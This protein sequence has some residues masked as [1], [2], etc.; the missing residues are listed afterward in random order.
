[1]T[2]PTD[3]EQIALSITWLRNLADK[4][5]KGVVNNIDA[6]GLGR[7]ADQLDAARRERDAALDQIAGLTVDFDDYRDASTAQIGALAARVEA[8]T[9]SLTAF[10][11][12]ALID[13]LMEGPKVLG[14]HRSRYI[15]AYEAARKAL[16]SVPEPA[17]EAQYRAQTDAQYLARIEQARV[18]SGDE[19]L[20]TVVG[21]PEPTR[22][23]TQE[24]VKMFDR[25]LYASTTIL[26]DGSEPTGLDTVLSGEAFDHLI[27]IIDNPPEPTQALK[28][29]MRGG[30][31]PTQGE[32]PS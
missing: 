25:A 30:S 13:A 19:P 1:M 28:D 4:G 29:L 18:K 22:N 20:N 27:S 6:R 9:A 23:I 11:D 31:E 7:V 3:A 14:I 2:A 8:L 12:A 24:E 5:G 16:S 15:E 17:P 26:D 32:G 21:G 10:C